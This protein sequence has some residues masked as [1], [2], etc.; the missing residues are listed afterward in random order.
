MHC[1]LY[2]YWGTDHIDPH[3][4]DSLACGVNVLKSKSRRYE[5]TNDK[6]AI[7]VSALTFVVAQMLIKKKKTTVHEH[8]GLR[9]DCM[10][11]S[12]T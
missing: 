2:Y 10:L 9:Y 7:A 3:K 5:A 4:I 8:S 1:G 12:C 11:M 6:R